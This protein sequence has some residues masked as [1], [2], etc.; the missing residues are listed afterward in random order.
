MSSRA[1]FLA[2]PEHLIAA[3][4]EAGA[5]RIL[6]EKVGENAGRNAGCKTLVNSDLSAISGGLLLARWL[7]SGH[8]R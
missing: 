7:A 3:L 6:E 8:F 1:D 4:G 2:N 5:E